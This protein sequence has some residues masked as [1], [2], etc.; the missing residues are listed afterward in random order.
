MLKIKSAKISSNKPLYW[1]QFYELS[2]G[3]FKFFVYLGLTSFKGKE[4]ENKAKIFFKFI[5]EQLRGD[6]VVRPKLLR[7]KEILE[8]STKQTKITSDDDLALVLLDDRVVSIV[9]KGKLKTFLLRDGK[10]VTVAASVGEVTSISGPIKSDDSFMV[11]TS[12]VVSKWGKGIIKASLEEESPE[13]S[14]ERLLAVLSSGQEKTSCLVFTV[15]REQYYQEK[16]KPHELAINFGVFKTLFR[17]FRGLVVFVLDF[18]IRLLPE[19]KIVVEAGVTDIAIEKKRKSAFL[20]AIILIFLLVISVFY[21]SRQRTL[22]IEKLKYETIVS[23][24]NHRLE[25]ALSL[26]GLNPDRSR[27]LV[28]SVKESL[29]NLEKLQIPESEYG[30]V[31]SRFDSVS[32]QVLGEYDTEPELFLDLTLSSDGF[33]GE[34][35]SLSHDTLH[36]LDKGGGKLLRIDINTKSTQITGGP[37][38]VSESIDLAGYLERAYVFKKDA[39]YRVDETGS[40]KVAEGDFGENALIKA[41]AGNV[42]ILDKSRSEILR[43]LGL[44]DN[45]GSGQTWLTESEG[46]DFS[47]IVSWAIDGSIWLLDR[48]GAVYRYASGRRLSVDSTLVSKYIKNSFKITTS[49]ENRNLYFLDSGSNKIVVFDKEGGFVAQYSTGELGNVK[50]IFVS[51]SSRKI[52]LLTG[53][54]L[55]TLE[56]KHLQ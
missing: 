38:E 34:M 22:K 29:P 27:E 3:N 55:Y 20:I 14:I 47:D 17:M 42:Y 31:I 32:G 6:E 5:E 8:L 13:S 30:E 45:L 35:G 23:D 49:E 28:L 15:S 2:F 43:Y 9:L 21:G 18:F 25:E 54:N 24:I 46:Q 56:L 11:T 44:G 41:Y 36:V 52:L 48:N 16:T 7:L 53:P 33:E 10:L 4:A 51:E 19:R 39:I 50:D 37:D 12:N 26:Y 40:K 1:S